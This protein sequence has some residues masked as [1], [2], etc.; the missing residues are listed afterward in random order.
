[1]LSPFYSGGIKSWVINSVLTFSLSSHRHTYVSLLFTSINNKPTVL[2]IHHIT[3]QHTHTRCSDGVPEPDGS[4]QKVV[5]DKSRHY[6]QISLNR[7]DPIPFMTVSVDT[8]G[9][10]YD[11]FNRLLF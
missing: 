7:P 8:S 9:R 6:R 11:D 4:L 5:R 1:M 2:F 3:C 10:A